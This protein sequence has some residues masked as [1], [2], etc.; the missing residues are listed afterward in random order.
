MA[1]QAID[2]A[3]VRT[4]AKNHMADL[5]AAQFGRRTPDKEIVAKAIKLRYLLK[6]LDMTDIEPQ[7][8][9]N[10]YQALLCLVPVYAVDTVLVLT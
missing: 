3:T 6:A 7:S 10:I 9:K 8:E 1:N 2:N 4:A 5:V